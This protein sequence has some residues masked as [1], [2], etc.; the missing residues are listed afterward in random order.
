MNAHYTCSRVNKEADYHAESDDKS[1]GFDLLSAHAVEH[2]HA[3]DMALQTQTHFL[4]FFFQRN[5]S[6][7]QKDQ[8]CQ[9]VACFRGTWKPKH[10]VGMALK[11]A[12]QEDELHRKEPLGK[13]QGC[14]GGVGKHS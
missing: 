1:P 13:G 6:I 7:Q 3:A 4:F 14:S 10:M 5:A 2:R 11:T 12:V 8:S 9:M